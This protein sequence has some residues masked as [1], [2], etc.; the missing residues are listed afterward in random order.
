MT[1]GERLRRL[2][3]KKGLSYDELAVEIKVP[4]QLVMRWE[5]DISVPDEEDLERLC[6]YY[7]LSAD[8]LTEGEAKTDGSLEGV[9]NK[10]YFAA[11][12]LGVILIIAIGSMFNIIGT[13]TMLLMIFA[14]VN[15]IVLILRL[16]R[17]DY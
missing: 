14:T 16:L 11:V 5:L 7:E 4:V 12:L 6:C 2:R 3:E 8:A 15:V 10:W 17:N 1:L 13:L 9:S